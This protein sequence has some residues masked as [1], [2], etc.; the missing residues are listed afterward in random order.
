MVT[1]VAYRWTCPECFALSSHSTQHDAETFKLGHLAEHA[2]L[3]KLEEQ[4]DAQ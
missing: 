2:A 4:N 1:D 3:K